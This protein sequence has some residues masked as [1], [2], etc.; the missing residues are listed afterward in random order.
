MKT[1]AFDLVPLFEVMGDGLVVLDVETQTVA[2]ANETGARLSGFAS[3]EVM[4]R[5]P[6]CLLAE[7]FQYFDT[8]GK[9][10][11]PLEHPSLKA[12]R[13]EPVA[14]VELVRRTVETGREERG[15]VSAIPLRDEAGRV[16]HVAMTFRPVTQQR[17]AERGLRLLARV[18]E[19][20]S[21]SLDHRATLHTLVHLVAPE[22][23]DTC[24]VKLQ[25]ADGTPHVEAAYP[26]PRLGELAHALR[27]RVSEGGV[28]LTFG[29]DEVIRTGQPQLL[30][31]ITPELIDALSPDKEMV[32]RLAE[33]GYRSALFVP[34]AARG[35]VLG[36]MTLCQWR[37]ERPPFDEAD[38]SLVMELASRAAFA[39]DNAL[40]FQQAREAEARSSHNEQR[41]VL[42]LE[43]ARMAY[44]DLD[45]ATGTAV[46]SP[47]IQSLYGMEPRAGDGPFDAFARV[48]PPEDRPWVLERLGRLLRGQSE[49]ENFAFRVIRSDG[50]VL[51]VDGFSKLLRDDAGRPARVL[52]V[53]QDATERIQAEER[54]R[55]LA[56]EQARRTQAEHER[57]AADRQAHYEA[58]RADVSLALA[59]PEPLPDSL[60]RCAEALAAHLPGTAAFVW[61]Y[62]AE[63]DLMEVKCRAGHPAGLE[64]NLPPTP[65]GKFQFTDV[66]AARPVVNNHF[67]HARPDV[68]E[69]L[70]TH[71]FTAFAG[72]PL[73]VGEQ[74]VGRV[75][76]FSV[77]PFPDDV[78]A[79]LGALADILAQGIKRRWAEEA[80]ERRAEELS[81]SNAELEQFAYV[82]SHDLQEPLRMVASYTQL[83]ARRY[84]GKLDESA[85]EFIAFAV[86]GVKR[87]QRLIGDLLA[88]SRV[89]TQRKPLVALR[90][91]EVL[92]RAI[93]NLRAAIEEKGA[94]VTASA[95]PEVL[96]DEVQLEQ[97]FQNLIG[98]GLKFHGDRAPK[99]HVSAEQVDG[100]W[101]FAVKD[102]GIGIEAKDFDRIFIIFQRLHGRGEYPGT[103]LGLAICKKI[104]ERHGGRIWVEAA[105]GEGATFFFTLPVLSPREPSAPNAAPEGSSR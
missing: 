61:L 104:V 38:L 58:L 40:L 74:L 79:A 97:L 75:T 6:A 53:A 103:G 52:G 56:L 105:P 78:T 42:A 64:V 93:S 46:Y 102:N 66:G 73:V 34:L 83:L 94:E 70:R 36:A 9:P 16:R 54:A 25:T 21:A 60:Q 31:E 50:T 5:T 22:F 8:Q 57:E 62:N 87:M 29:A 55:A 39:V 77:P 63:T 59:R 67:Q 89:D 32:G 86:D 13:G 35:R 96:G 4:M 47:R 14:P 51:H 82:A 49:D 28:P 84:R 80:L 20:M 76:M 2:H 17:R 15:L 30:K 19:L 3:A 69:W 26:T 65:R 24:V 33:L 7:R 41:L 71:G 27:R 11:P 12:A 48:L 68:Q 100:F 37:P 72:I 18:N 1:P 88:Y 43:A 98:N 95:L 44:F 90:S 91:D 92:R 99:V 85:D 10:L 45:I 101:R 81:R 23:A